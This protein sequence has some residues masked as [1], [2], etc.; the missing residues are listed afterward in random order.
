MN[1]RMGELPPDWAL[2]DADFDIYEEGGG[3][4]SHRAQPLSWPPRP[5]PAVWGASD[6]GS[7]C[8]D[9][10]QCSTSSSSA[11]RRGIAIPYMEPVD[12]CVLPSALLL[13]CASVYPLLLNHDDARFGMLCTSY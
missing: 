2:Y 11:S 1:L 9:L 13:V 4:T 3:P 7:Q 8:S 12:R 10:S 6:A 5:R